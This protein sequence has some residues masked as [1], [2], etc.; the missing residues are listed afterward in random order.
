MQTVNKYV[1]D[2]GCNTLFTSLQTIQIILQLNN[3]LV[4]PSINLLIAKGLT[5]IRIILYAQH[6][7]QRPHIV[8]YSTLVENSCSRGGVIWSLCRDLVPR[9]SL[10]LTLGSLPW[11]MDNSFSSNSS[12][13]NGGIKWGQTDTLTHTLTHTQ[14]ELLT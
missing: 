4:L 5:E 13:A 8:Q 12:N 1:M 3:L 10:L 11:L 7:C 2:P 6:R 9:D 14:I